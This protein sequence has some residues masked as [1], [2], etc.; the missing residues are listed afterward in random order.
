MES[1]APLDTA[2]S[3][4]PVTD[5]LRPPPSA[6]GHTSVD[7]GNLAVYSSAAIDGAGLSSARLKKR[8]TART[9]QLV[10]Q[11]FSAP[12]AGR[13][14]EGGRLVV[15][16]D[17]STPVPRAKPVPVAKPQTRWE[18]FAQEKGIM[19][20]KR[21]RFVLDEKHDVERPRYGYG[22]VDTDGTSEMVLEH[23]PSMNDGLDDGID[24][25]TQA[26]NKKKDRIAKNKEQQRMNQRRSMK[27]STS[28]LGAA[29]PDLT[30]DGK[31]HR[32]SATEASAAYEIAR[33][34]TASVGK[35]DSKHK[36]EPK[37]HRGKRKFQSATDSVAGDGKA[38]GK[39]MDRV[40][41]GN[42]IVNNAKAIKQS[43]DDVG[44]QV[45]DE[46]NAKAR[47]HKS[48]KKLKGKAAAAVAGARGAQGNS[49]REKKKKW[50]N[51]GF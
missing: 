39:I 3:L 10:E 36:L 27:E 32:R 29:L 14:S 2:A 26:D 49:K 51:A 48:T 17:G 12:G 42:A 9:Q 28:R 30:E 37:Q 20:K 18:K 21:S 6:Q 34:S 33:T 38:I 44:A 43:H 15:L 1:K 31:V 40:L 5:L 11:L 46:E 23:K 35:F 19:K 50:R 25:F 41:A 24:P 16:P 8:A 13:P 4:R 45:A 22:R 47:K 7:L